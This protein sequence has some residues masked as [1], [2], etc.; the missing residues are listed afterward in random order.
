MG[1]MSCI[2]YTMATDNWATKS[3]FM[4]ST[5]DIAFI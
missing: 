4:S 3:Q 2:V 1:D 5:G